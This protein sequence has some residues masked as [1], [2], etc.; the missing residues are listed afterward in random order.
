M[1][2]GLDEVC[3]N[4]LKL[5]FW[6]LYS[7][8]ELVLYNIIKITIKIDIVNLDELFVHWTNKSIAYEQSNH[9]IG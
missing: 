1:M 4:N 5:M 3:L 9:M 6:N 2:Q 8:L 7:I